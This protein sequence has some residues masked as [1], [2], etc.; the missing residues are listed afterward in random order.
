MNN[1]NHSKSWIS[2]LHS[3]ISNIG[4]WTV[5]LISIMGLF[6]P[7]PI[8]G[9][10]LLVKS[11]SGLLNSFEMG[12]ISLGTALI[13][14]VRIGISVYCFVVE[15]RVIRSCF[16]K[17]RICAD[18]IEACFPHKKPETYLW[19]D[20]QEVSICY[21]DNHANTNVKPLKLICFIRNGEKKNIFGRWKIDAFWRYPRIVRLNYTP[22]LFEEVVKYCPIRIVDRSK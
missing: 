14:T 8:Y 20:F 9:I 16:T 13:F 4:T 17:H 22:E 19:S 3:W 11:I 18:G 2:R 1:L 7:A 15:W 6:L 10:S 21:E 12:D 5:A